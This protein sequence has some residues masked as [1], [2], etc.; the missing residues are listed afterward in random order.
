M[1]AK[2][3]ASSAV[4]RN[5]SA[6]EAASPASFQPWNAHTIA[7]A[8]RPSG[9]RSHTSGCIR[10]TVHHGRMAAAGSAHLDLPTIAT[11]REDDDVDGVFACTRK[12]RR[13][14]RTGSPYLLLEL[15]DSTGTVDARA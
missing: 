15:A 9:R 4:E 13:V 5:D 3:R 14:S 6:V 1:R 12:E 11:L 10:T 8:R 2:R 7:G